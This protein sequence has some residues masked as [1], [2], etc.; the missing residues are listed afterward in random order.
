MAVI[1]ISHRDFNE[2]L[3]RVPSG[4]SDRIKAYQIQRELRYL[5][6]DRILY[7]YNSHGMNITWILTD[8]YIVYTAELP[9]N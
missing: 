9:V 4:L 3:Q 7:R 1:A 6:L 8:K 2:R 5:S